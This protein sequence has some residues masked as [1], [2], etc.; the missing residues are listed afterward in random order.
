MLRRVGKAPCE[1]VMYPG[2][3]HH[4]YESGKPSHRLDVV[5]RMEQWIRRWT[6]K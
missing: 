5:R 6:G 3:D 4:L 1:M 2:G